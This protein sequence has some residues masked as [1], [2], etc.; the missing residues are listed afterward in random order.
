MDVQQRWFFAFL[1]ICPP[2]LLAEKDESEE[3]IV[4]S[5]N[6]IKL[7]SNKESTS[8]LIAFL[9]QLIIFFVIQFFE[10]GFELVHTAKRRMK[11]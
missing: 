9:I 11:N 2:R 1:V 6:E 7:Y 3:K 8:I 10:F 4:N 5:K